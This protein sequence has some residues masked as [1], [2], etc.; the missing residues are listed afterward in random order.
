MRNSFERSFLDHLYERNLRLPDFAQCAPAPDVFLQPDFY[1]RRGTIPG[2]CVFIDGPHHAGREARERR[3]REPLED[4]GYRIV[5]ITANRPLAEQ[6]DAYPDVFA[7]A[8]N[9]R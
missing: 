6:I 7:P 8:T 5:V 3:A 9:G 1:Y 2:V 4:R